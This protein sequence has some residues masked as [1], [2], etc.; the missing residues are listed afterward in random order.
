MSKNAKNVQVEN[1]TTLYTFSGNSAGLK[2]KLCKQKQKEKKSVK[3][4]KSEKA[5]VL[6]RTLAKRNT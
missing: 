5:N 2:R 6:S 4:I 3:L 1:R